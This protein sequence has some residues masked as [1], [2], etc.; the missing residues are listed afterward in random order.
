METQF[1]FR[2]LSLDLIQSYLSN[3]SQYT[4]INNHQSY[5]SNV[6][7]GV[8]QGSSLSSL[9]FLI[10]INDLPTASSFETILFADDAFLTLLDKI[11]NSL[12][13]RVNDKLFKI[14]LWLRTYL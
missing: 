4:K 7:C 10:Y 9:L 2:G 1:G 11:F 6:N 8:S 14:D 13:K 12:Q 3:R 5:P